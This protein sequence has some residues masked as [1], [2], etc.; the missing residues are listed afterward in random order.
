MCKI[1][2]LLTT[3]GLLLAAAGSALAGANPDAE[4]ALDCRA[5]ESRQCGGTYADC[6]SIQYQYP[7]TGDY[8]IQ[9][10]SVIQVNVACYPN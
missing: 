9:D 5:H 2:V 4:L 7:G 6:G 1:G 3:L 10:P 8:D